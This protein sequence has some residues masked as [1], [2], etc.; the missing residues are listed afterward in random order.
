MS[1]KKDDYFNFIFNNNR[2]GY[3]CYIVWVECF[4][5][6][7]SRVRFEDGT[8]ITRKIIKQQTYVDF[9]LIIII[10]IIHYLFVLEEKR[11]L[12]EI[13]LRFLLGVKTFSNRIE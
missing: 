11:I 5:I 13:L 4:L 2:I 10:I 1:F 7:K 12:I 8:K 9:K 6:N 3:C